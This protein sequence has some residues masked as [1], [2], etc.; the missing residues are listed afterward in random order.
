MIFF[1]HIP[2]TAGT[3]F[4]E[5]VKKNYAGFLKPKLNKLSEI[6]LKAMPYQSAIRL[7]GGYYSAPQTLSIMLD[8]SSLDNA[9]FI[10]GHVGYGFHHVYNTRVDYISFVREPKER[11][12]S[13][14]KEHCK[15]GRLF[16]DKLFDKQFDINFYFE[17]VLNENLDNIMT[18]QIA[19]PYDF[20]LHERE[21]VSDELYQ[22]ALGNMHDITF[23]SQKNFDKALMYMSKEFNWNH[24]GYKRK[25]VA[26][27]YGAVTDHINE[28]LLEEVIQYDLKLYN[29]VA[30]VN[31]SKLSKIEKVLF[32]LKT[33]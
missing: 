29:E 16:Y 1:I 18:R 10:G 9:A 4:Y 5:V 28:S 32:K 27:P 8:N 31:S 24:L 2:K 22:K 26:K 3:T 13:D 6:D 17:L 21:Q 30:V 25:N 12:I 15:P 11:L 19:G 33:W 23:F 7:P 20:Y 14:Y